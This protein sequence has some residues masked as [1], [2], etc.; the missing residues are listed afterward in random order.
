MP[1]N[2]KHALSLTEGSVQQGRSHFD[3]RSVLPVRERERRK[4]RQVCEPEGQ[5]KGRRCLREP[6]RQSQGTPLACQP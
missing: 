6:L 4:E 3:A 1:G 5:A 2:K